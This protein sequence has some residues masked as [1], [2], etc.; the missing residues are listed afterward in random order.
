MQLTVQTRGA[1]YSANS[2]YKLTVQTCA[3]NLRCKLEVQTH[4]AESQCK[5]EACCVANLRRDESLT[6]FPLA[7]RHTLNRIST[8]S[9]NTRAWRKE[10]GKDVNVSFREVFHEF[11]IEG[12][13]HC[14]LLKT[15]REKFFGIYNKKFQLH[16]K[17]DSFSIGLFSIIDRHS[18]NKTA[19]IPDYKGRNIL[20]S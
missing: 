20:P 4:G 13:I 17:S 15:S 14:S 6:R 19:L 9:Y 16:E 3:A 7:M 8:W 10:K 18:A 11:R 12:D 5:V 1:T 2:R